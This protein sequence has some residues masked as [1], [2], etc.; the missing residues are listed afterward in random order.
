MKRYFLF[1][2]LFVPFITIHAQ[3]TDF[4]NGFRC[5]KYANE[6]YGKFQDN[7][8]DIILPNSNQPTPL[9][10]FIHGGGFLHG[11][12]K[13]FYYRKEDI[14]YLLEHHIAVAT[15]NYRFYKTDDSLGVK[16]CIQDIERAV[17]YI[18]FN[19]AKYHIDKS[20][21]GCYGIS[22]GAGASLYLAFHDDMAIAGDTTL[23]G[24]STRIKCAGAID[25]Q[26]TYDVFAWK[27]IIPWLGF[28][29]FL[30]Q[31]SFYNVAANFY[32]YPTY[33]SFKPQKDRIEKSLDILGMIDSNDPPVYLMNLQKETFPRNIDIIE[34]HQRHATEVSKTLYRYGVKNYCYTYKK[35]LIEKEQDIDYPISKFFAEQLKQ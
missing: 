21:V 35:H 11:D 27:E 3:D 17:Q 1:L 5:K 33:K 30:K 4:L 20:R 7:K 14:K 10:I 2:I 25:T 16:V 19:A 13:N 28:V 32:G 6:S 23:L 31:H 9:V 8:F 15:I 29:M 26:S 18:R 12:K 22:A 24:E 34:H